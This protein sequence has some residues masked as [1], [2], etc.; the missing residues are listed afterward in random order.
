MLG[1]LA[2]WLRLFGFDTYYANEEIDDDELLNIARDENRIIVTR[3]KHLIWRA[4]K[5]ELPV[6][7][8]SSA[9]LDD[10]LRH[11]LMDVTIDD[12]QILSRCSLCNTPLLEVKKNDVENKVPEKVF[13]RNEKFWWCPLCDKLYWT[14]TH[15]QKIINKIDKIK[16]AW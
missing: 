1:T 6:I 4:E 5:K 2:R 12:H 13:N 9:N 10:Q 7:S 3:D 16:Q 11:V 15:Y 14:G 8:I